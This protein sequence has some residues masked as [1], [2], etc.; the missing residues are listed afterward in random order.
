MLGQVSLT[1][2]LRVSWPLKRLALKII[3][4]LQHGVPGFF[5]MMDVEMT[6][7]SAFCFILQQRKSKQGIK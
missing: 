1:G 6:V 7:S 2:G 5:K 4:Q 3:L